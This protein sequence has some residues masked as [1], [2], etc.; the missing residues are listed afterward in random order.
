MKSLPLAEIRSVVVIRTDHVGDLVLSTPF[1]RA[2]RQG[3]PQARITAL[4]PPYTSQVLQGSP[5]VDEVL[6]HD[7]LARPVALEQV[8][9]S[10]PDL[11][12]SLAPRSRS[13]RLAW[14]T[15]AR[16]RVG[17]VYAGRPLAKL[18]CQAWLTHRMTVDL[19]HD[20][21]AGRPIPHEIEQLQR[22]AGK[23]GLPCQE[24]GLELTIPQE[25]LDFGR[26]L[27]EGWGSQ[28][29]ALHLSGGWVTE[30]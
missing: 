13:Y 24:D 2:L 6:V 5:L 22:L 25:D 21:A 14:R 15:G 11:A 29:A 4:L 18:A 9:A 10:R 8:R 23:M 17:Y 1:L 30:G 3:L 19:E 20:L 28:K 27:V 7:R 16:Y 12:I 26:H